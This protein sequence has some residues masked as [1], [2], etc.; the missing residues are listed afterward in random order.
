MAK[1]EKKSVIWTVCYMLSD[2]RDD[3]TEPFT[4][5]WFA[6]GKTAEEAKA[7]FLRD[8]HQ[9]PED[10]YGATE[11]TEIYVNHVFKGFSC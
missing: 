7:N 10:F 6:Y 4:A 5:T 9:R 1:K 11:K 8:F 3:P 2:E